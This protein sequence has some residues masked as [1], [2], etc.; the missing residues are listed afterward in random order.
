MN[1]D[2]ERGLQAIQKAK[3]A[4]QGGYHKEARRW[5]ELAVSLA[6][7]AEEAWLWLAAVSGPRA[8]LNYLNRALKI[9]P[10]SARARQGIHWAV[11]RLRD[12][13]FNRD[14]EIP[15]RRTIVDQSIQT[16]E[17]VLPGSKPGV[18]GTA[19][20]VTILAVL[21]GLWAWSGSSASA[22]SKTAGIA[23]AQI[24]V[25]PRNNPVVV[26]QANLDKA[27]RTPTPT[28][29]FTP[30]PTHTPTAT[31]TDT[32]TPTATKRP[33]KTPVPTKKPTK[34]PTEEPP[35]QA[36]FEDQVGPAPVA[37]SENWVDVNLS[38]QMAYAYRGRKLINSFLVST[39]TWQYPTVTGQYHIY[40]KYRYA[41]M[42]GPGYYL[43]NVPYVM[44]FYKGYG[45]HGTYWHHNFGT[46]MS[47][48]CINFSIP[49][50]AWLFDFAEVGTLVNIHY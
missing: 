34:V 18:V 39:G 33:T 45:L 9:N 27:T 22:F 16:R 2:K 8:S 44:Y 10:K 35:T 48:G 5:A 14:Q 43:P 29:T 42:T 41:D 32:P 19:L 12:P 6:P 36:P 7:E 46:P 3:L 30:T 26:A 1:P 23:L 40:V 50:A 4:Y 15:R 31:P 13:T 17:M 25:Q 49:D 37:D 28:A 38:Q 21:F 47:H 20:I 11:Q 24:G